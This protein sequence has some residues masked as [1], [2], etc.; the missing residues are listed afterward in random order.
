MAL[1]LE[2][3]KKNAREAI[4]RKMHGYFEKIYDEIESVLDNN[5][6]TIR[7]NLRRIAEDGYCSKEIKS[8][9]TCS[10]YCC[11]KDWVAFRDILTEG[12]KRFYINYINYHVSIDISE[13]LLDHLAGLF[14]YYSYLE[15]EISTLKDKFELS[16]RASVAYDSIKETIDAEAW[17]A[18]TKL[19]GD[20][21]DEAMSNEKIIPYI[22]ETK[23][24]RDLSTLEGFSLSVSH[25]KKFTDRELK[26]YT[27]VQKQEDPDISTD[28]ILKS[29]HKSLKDR[30]KSFV[31]KL[32]EEHDINFIE[33]ND[34]S[35]TLVVGEYSNHPVSLAYVFDINVQLDDYQNL[36]K[37]RSLAFNTPFELTQSSEVPEYKSAISVLFDLY[38][39]F[40]HNDIFI[41][42]NGTIL[43][44]EKGKTNC[45]RT[46]YSSSKNT[47]F[48]R[49]DN[50]NVNL[51]FPADSQRDLS[52]EYIDIAIV[53]KNLPE[54]PAARYLISI[55]NLASSKK[56]DSDCNRIIYH[57]KRSDL[58][59]ILF[60]E[61]EA[62]NRLFVLE[63]KRLSELNKHKQEVK[64][65]SLTKMP[66]IF[67]E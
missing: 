36:L 59:Q 38:I 45:C 49:P 26:K 6:N 16:Q 4:K 2:E 22:D 43:Q 44:Q 56:V 57:I 1:S 20:F 19:V 33:Y 27:F 40:L 11:E 50:I 54:G 21:L 23:S 10:I 29:R 25:E 28:D 8:E 31:K 32:C 14:N 53:P 9:Y 39:N 51:L 37:A 62:V 47:D 42:E 5:L 67:D 18:A 41:Y 35:F 34:G 65:N 66:N 52:D 17:D 61:F 3:V 30:I 15:K 58:S 24:T 7:L 55:L 63:K 13:A 46:V 48:S 60:H 12:E 64:T